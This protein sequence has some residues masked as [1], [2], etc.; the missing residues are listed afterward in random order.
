[1]RV[2]FWIN[3]K[4]IFFSQIKNDAAKGAI[5]IAPFFLYLFFLIFGNRAPVLLPQVFGPRDK[6]SPEN[7]ERMNA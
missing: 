5:K 7:L 2:L 1:M 6:G 4:I 3:S